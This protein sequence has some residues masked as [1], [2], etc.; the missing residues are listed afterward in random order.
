MVTGRR[1]WPRVVSFW[2]PAAAASSRWPF[3]DMDTP[4]SANVIA[5][6]VPDRE[7]VAAAAESA[8]AQ[9]RL[10]RAPGPARRVRPVRPD[11]PGRGPEPVHWVRQADLDLGFRSDG[12]TAGACV[13][14]GAPGRLSASG[15]VPGAASS[16]SGYY[17]WLK[18]PPSARARRDAE[19]KGRIVAEWIESG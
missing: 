7:R 4:T 8:D 19:L 11:Q 14:E 18:R 10:R 6:E 12:M 13:H 15:D 5:L 16:P 3:L 17:G 9:S 2:W 1:A